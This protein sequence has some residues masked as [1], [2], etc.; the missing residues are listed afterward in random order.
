MCF[1]I[2]GSNIGPMG[3]S[4][5]LKCGR[6]AATPK[7]G[8]YFDCPKYQV[9]YDLTSDLEALQMLF[10]HSKKPNG[11]NRTPVISRTPFNS[12]LEKLRSELF[13]FNLTS[14]V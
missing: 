11:K 10:V 8:P 13:Q 9:L 12:V 2:S 14:P 1:T 5:R 7:Y 3:A 4:N 6:H